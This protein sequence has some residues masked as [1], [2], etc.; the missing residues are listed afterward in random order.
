MGTASDYRLRVLLH[1]IKIIRKICAFAQWKMF[2]GSVGY[3]MCAF[4][5]EDGAAC[6][7]IHIYGGRLAFYAGVEFSTL[8]LYD[9]K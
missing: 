4:V 8:H 2:S 1:L 5:M 7:G 6:V 9:L 3:R